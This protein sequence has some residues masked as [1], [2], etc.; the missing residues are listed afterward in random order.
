[1][2]YDV[3]VVDSGPLGNSACFSC[4]LTDYEDASWHRV[5]NFT[6]GILQTESWVYK[7]ARSAIPE[8]CPS[9]PGWVQN[10][11][12]TV[13][14]RIKEMAELGKPETLARFV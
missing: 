10:L 4:A 13:Y 11:F 9:P 3:N 5:V 7:E 1:M 2:I 8:D 6:A 12:N 14:P